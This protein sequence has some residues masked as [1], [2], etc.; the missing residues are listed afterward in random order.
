MAGVRPSLH[1]VPLAPGDPVPGVSRYLAR[2]GL[3]AKLSDR[4]TVGGLFRLNGP[5]TP[6]GEPAVRTQSYVL[7]D[8]DG[9]I[10]IGR[11]GWTLDWE[12]QNLFNTRY[13]E[14]RSSGYLN[15][16]AP[17]VLRMAVRFQP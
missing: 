5:F 7:A 1:L 9:T 11:A 16:G 10:S 15:P 4:L 13:P 8:L 3:E 2:A 12:L 17:R 6:I 14:V